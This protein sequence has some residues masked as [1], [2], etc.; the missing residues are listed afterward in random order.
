MTGT[1]TGQGVECP[2][3]RGDDGRLYSLAGN[4]GPF[5]P[6]DRVR[7]RGEIA[8]MSF[9]MQGTTISVRSIRPAF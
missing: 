2:V 4:T 1:M 6:G 8:Q 7:V 3:M 5:G 9:C